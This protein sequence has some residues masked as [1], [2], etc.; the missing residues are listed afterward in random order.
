VTLNPTKS[1]VL[2]SGL[3]AWLVGLIA[4]ILPIWHIAMPIKADGMPPWKGYEVA[5]SEH[6]W[7]VVRWRADRRGPESNFP[8]LLQEDVHNIA[9]G[10]LI[11][12]FSAAFG[13]LCYWMI[14]EDE[15]QLTR[16]ASG[17]S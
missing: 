9:V 16:N 15:Q 5:T 14:F 11:L 8:G 13:R 6:L 1:P 10:F 12:A 4:S 17:E 7:H 3:S 2:F